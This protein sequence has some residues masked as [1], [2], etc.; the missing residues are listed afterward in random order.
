MKKVLSAAVTGILLLG[1]VLTVNAATGWQKDGNAWVYVSESGIKTTGWIQDGGSWYHL[2]ATGVMQTGWIQ[3]GGKWYYMNPDGS[4]K[5]GWIQDGE[6]WYYLNADGSMKTGWLQLGDLWYY[7]YD[8]GSMATMTVIDGCSI[9]EDGS[10]SDPSWVMVGDYVPSWKEELLAE[11]NR[12]RAEAGLKE[13]KVTE[14]AQ[15]YADIRVKEITEKYSGMVRPDGSLSYGSCEFRWEGGATGLS[16]LGLLKDQVRNDW[17]ELTTSD[18]V[19]EFGISVYSKS[20]TF[21]YYVAYETYDKETYA[22][23]KEEGIVDEVFEYAFK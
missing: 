5:T 14:W 6:K 12:I 3:D 22:A 8:D 1:S 20:T 7:L 18:D 9:Y 15:K 2:D 10:W 16:D 13:I 17:D 11:L 23:I 19:V 4:M 21:Y